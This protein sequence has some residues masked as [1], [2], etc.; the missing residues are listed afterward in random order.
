MKKLLLPSILLIFII[1]SGWAAAAGMSEI[2]AGIGDV[3]F[4]Q[5]DG[6][7]V[8]ISTIKK[9]KMAVLAFWSPE[10]PATKREVGKLHQ[11]IQKQSDGTIMILV[12]RGQSAA[13]MQSAVLSA[14]EIGLESRVYFD[15]ELAAAKSL[16]VKSVPWFIAVGRDDKVL[17][18]GF[19]SLETKFR[20]LTV[21]QIFSKFKSGEKI[22]FYEFIPAKEG[23]KARGLIGGKAPGFDARDLRNN[24]Q[25]TEK[26]RNKKPLFIVFWR[27]SCPHCRME[28]PKLA[29]FYLKN[30]DKKGFEMVGLAITGKPGDREKVEGFV[31]DQKITFP[32]IVDDGGKISGKY[33]INSVPTIFYISR[34]GMIGEV[35]TGE[36][37]ELDRLLLS[38][39]DM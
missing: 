17:S 28:M 39:L 20:N 34:N 14:K 6:K 25:S 19:N 36:T 29:K 13:D 3:K 11:F 2:G 30:K 8:S 22:P 9:G 15:P 38:F 10:S 23:D 7:K 5:P 1:N 21:S 35:Q 12:S 18:P 26:Y 27:E 31:S 24:V 32:I 4:V 16:E 37:Q 33:N